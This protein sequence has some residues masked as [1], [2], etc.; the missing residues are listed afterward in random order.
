MMQSLPAINL[1]Q[2]S[3]EFPVT[4]DNFTSKI[5]NFPPNIL[6]SMSFKNF[7]LIS[8]VTT[9][10]TQQW[11]LTKLQEFSNVKHLNFK[12][13]QSLKNAKFEIPRYENFYAFKQILITFE[14]NNDGHVI[15]SW[16]NDI[17]KI[18]QWFSLD[19]SYPASIKI[20][21]KKFFDDNLPTIRSDYFTSF[22]SNEVC[23]AHITDSQNQNLL[24][25][26]VD[27][28]NIEVCKNLLQQSFD[29]NQET[30]NRE[31]AADIAWRKGN[32]EILLLLLKE[33]SIYPKNFNSR[34]ASQEILSFLNI[35]F[36]LHELIEQNKQKD[37]EIFLKN[38]KSL[39]YFY[40]SKNVSAAAFAI[41]EKNIYIYKTLIDNN[42]YFGPNED[43]N[44]YMQ[45]LDN[46]QKRELSEFHVNR[47]LE[48]PEKH[49]MILILNSVVSHDEQTVNERE[50]LIKEAFMTL[51]KI[52]QIKLIME[53]VA[54]SKKLKIFFDFNRS[55]VQFMVPVTKDSSTNGLF[56]LNGKIYI[57]AKDFLKSSTRLQAIAVLA[58]ELCHF[59]MLIV[60]G[61]NCKP[62]AI[63]DIF[64]QE[65]FEKILKQ[66]EKNKTKEE[67]INLVFACYRKAVQH[68]ELIVRVPHM[69]A[70]YHEKKEL[71][72]LRVTF[73]SLFEYFENIVMEDMNDN[74][75]LLKKLNS[76]NNNLKFDDLTLI[77]KSQIFHA[78]VNFQNHEVKFK[79]ILKNDNS[80]VLKKLKPLQISEIINGKEIRIN[81]HNEVLTD[82]FVDVGVSKYLSDDTFDKWMG[83]DDF[84]KEIEKQKVVIVL[85]NAD[86]G[87][88]T[89]FRNSCKKLIE[90]H[91]THWISY[92]DLKSFFEIYEKYENASINIEN[93]LNI[94]IEMLKLNSY[95]E[96][97]I[98]KERFD[99]GKVILMFDDFDE[100]APKFSKFFLKFVNFIKDNSRNQQLISSRLHHKN[101]LKSKLI[102]N[103]SFYRLGILNDFGQEKLI[104]NILEKKNVK[105]KKLLLNNIKSLLFFLE[106][107]EKIDSPLLI[108]TV[109]ELCCENEKFLSKQNIYELYEEIWKIKKNILKNDK[110]KISNEFSDHASNI[111][112]W[113]IH[114]MYAL[115]NELGKSFK[116]FKNSKKEFPLEYFEIF[117]KWKTE[118][119]KWTAEAIAR[120]GFMYVENWNTENEEP[121]FVHATYRDFFIAQFIIENLYELNENLNLKFNENELRVELLISITNWYYTNTNLTKDFLYWFF[122]QSY[123]RKKFKIQKQKKFNVGILEFLR[124]RER[125]SMHQKSFIKIL[126]FFSQDREIFDLL[127]DRYKIN[128]KCETF[129]F[130]IESENID[131]LN[132]VLDLVEI[133]ERKFGQD[134]YKNTGYVINKDNS[135]EINIKKLNFNK[136]HI[137]ESEADFKVLETYGRNFLKLLNVIKVSNMSKNEFIKVFKCHLSEIMNFAM[138]STSISKEI[139]RFFHIYFKGS[140]KEFCIIFKEHL[141]KTEFYDCKIE[142]SNHF[143]KEYLESVKNFWILTNYFFDTELQ[144]ELLSQYS[145]KIM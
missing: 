91:K 25:K 114:Q 143:N 130:L 23:I 82:N 83:S 51:N 78:Y 139:F 6:Q 21:V 85:G 104:S 140:D 137:Y 7:S 50:I 9:L 76:E 120:Y 134:W 63:D 118:Q 102:P 109:T 135:L 105:D 122:I 136:M 2:L 58:H 93:C 30:I 123:L 72:S 119:S 41:N 36:K 103:E 54:T 32:F 37:I 59:A 48:L 101:E 129:K 57:A 60:Y 18:F 97:D 33:N 67:I 89:F 45:K 113:Q 15:F 74:L 5:N 145:D 115:K 12:I 19:D 13:T 98:F 131:Q 52:S 86:N 62:Y 142:N 81:H 77:L 70:H 42:V 138:R 125:I 56:Y 96:Q 117:S 64:L 35:S 133:Y 110:G 128:N 68:A 108:K 38:H 10:I 69:L 24:I 17:T 144:N 27:D 132:R 3:F 99:E 79:T 43:A 92:F 26:A 112:I 87:K 94:L 28:E 49:L 88:T 53:V 84:L 126:E 22:F 100:I 75:P 90:F 121:F 80:E 31:T 141:E 44:E 4:E 1:S 20:F 11:F 61:N 127:T 55:S 65:K 46:L 8:D 40:N 106:H 29:I 111:T 71:K 47:S 66:C 95:M 39:R 116:E 16:K 14:S 107:S 124:K 34:Q 73:S